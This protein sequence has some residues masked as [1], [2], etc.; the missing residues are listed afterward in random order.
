MFSIYPFFQGKGN[1]IKP[2]N[3]QNLGYIYF[4]AWILLSQRWNKFS[5]QYF[6]HQTQASQWHFSHFCQ[7]ELLCKRR[8]LCKC[9]FCKSFCYYPFYRI[10]KDHS[11]GNW[12]QEAR[13]SYNSHLQTSFLISLMHINPKLNWFPWPSQILSNFL[14]PGYYYMRSVI[15]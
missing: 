10:T 15:E 12:L 11:Q 3:I 8:E 2:Q 7:G 4:T 1:K 9:F 13:K 6:Y 14:T 5:F